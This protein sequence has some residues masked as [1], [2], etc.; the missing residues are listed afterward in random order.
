MSLPT[1]LLS[2]LVPV[3]NVAPYL[4]QCLDS[5]LSQSYTALEVIVVD[6]GSTDGSGAICDAY[7]ERDARIRLIH[8]ANAGLSAARNA[9][10][11]V[12]HGDFFVCVD[13]DDWLPEDALEQPMNVLTANP[14]IDI[15]ELGYTEI[16][17]RTG[18]E[19]LV[20]A[21]GRELS[22]QEALQSLAALSGV[23]G[24][25]WGDLPHRYDGA[26]R[27]PV[28]ALRDTPFIFEALTR[29]TRYRYL[30]WFGY[31]Y[32]VARVGS[33]TEVYDKRLVY[34]FENLWT[35]R[36]PSGDFARGSATPA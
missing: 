30:S 24:M 27:F 11:D 20:L 9:A 6:D 35:S 31:C 22:S 28:G 19:R 34:L 17:C 16:N 8:Q 12:M 7:A 26:L 2:V 18:A 33:I 5:I 25:A 10:M 21:A 15:L 1:P 14:L 23:T 4:E 29:A 3:Y 32:R 36:L 13:S